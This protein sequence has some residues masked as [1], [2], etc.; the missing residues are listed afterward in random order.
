V[1]AHKICSWP[2]PEMDVIAVR[3]EEPWRELSSAG[4]IRK[5]P[6]N[7]K[8]REHVL[9]CPL[10]ATSCIPGALFLLAFPGERRQTFKKK[11]KINESD[12]VC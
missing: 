7:Q 6:S 3:S 11:K 12:A 4:E 10:Q 1:T 5:P 8:R 9:V 2:N